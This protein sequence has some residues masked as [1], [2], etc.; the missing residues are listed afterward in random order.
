MARTSFIPSE[1]IAA[2]ARWQFA[3]VSPD[4]VEQGGIADPE[5]LREAHR[6]GRAEGHAAGRAEAMAEA[7]QRMDEYVAHQGREA[8][9]RLAGLFAAAEEGLAAAQQDIARGT[10]EIAC[11]LAR[12]V[13]RQELAGNPNALEPVVRE[14]LDLLLADGKSARVRLSH[15]DF[16]ML[17]APLGEAFSA[18]AVTVTADAAVAPGDC[19]IESAGAVIDGG[20]AK[21]WSRAVASLGLELP[22]NEATPD[23]A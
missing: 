6:L 15:V 20:V 19:L 23:A 21:R 8:A 14:A 2:C 17:H 4:G 13:I 11:A 3:T 10:L 9:Q 22:W 7:R 1:S 5:A 16:D 18:Q 12:Q